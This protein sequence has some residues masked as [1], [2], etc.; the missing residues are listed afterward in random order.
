M[1]CGLFSCPL[2]NPLEHLYPLSDRYFCS[3]ATASFRRLS[4]GDHH[5]GT[6]IIVLRYLPT[7]RRRCQILLCKVCGQHMWALQGCLLVKKQ[8]YERWFANFFD[9]SS[10]F[11]L[12][13]MNR[14]PVFS[15]LSICLDVF[16]PSGPIVARGV[17]WGS[18]LLTLIWAH[19][20]VYN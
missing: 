6:G 14:A 4:S 10:V 15:R 13:S 16:R 12:G 8:S 3:G 9:P 7:C 5:S 11:G 20:L 19:V 2:Q 1:A 18:P 17:S